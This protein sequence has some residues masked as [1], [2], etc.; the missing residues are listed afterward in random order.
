[1]LARRRGPTIQLHKVGLLVC[2]KE[3]ARA[4]PFDDV[5]SVTSSALR[6]HAFGRGVERHVLETRGGPVVF[7]HSFARAPA[8]L[9]AIH[10]AT[11]ER[12]RAEALRRYDAG[13]ALA[14]GPFAVSEGG[15]RD[16]NGPLVP[17]QEL[18]RGV[19]D[20]PI[21]AE[22]QLRSRV[23]VWKKLATA[24]LAS[25][26]SEQVPNASVMLD[27]VALAIDASEEDG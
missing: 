24:P 12:L 9:A 20:P 15:F 8:L 1:M 22:G 4:I 2:A 3:G 7:G 16:G 10:A 17:W 18:D 26:P 19:L 25:Y 23:N 14:F 6:R 13:E 27:I 21:V 5:R 11:R